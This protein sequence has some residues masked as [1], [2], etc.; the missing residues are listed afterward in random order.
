M[1]YDVYSNGVWAKGR[2]QPFRNQCPSTLVSV[3]EGHA[4]SKAQITETIAQAR[5]AQYHWSRRPQ[6]QRMDILT[7]YA[8][9]LRERNEDI[10]KAISQDMGKP[11]W[12]SR[13]EANAMAAKIDISMKALYERAGD[14]Q[15]EVAFGRTHLIHRAHGVMAV[16]GPFN[17]PG[18]LPNGHIVPALLAGNV[19]VFK[20]SE[21]APSVA[22]LMVEAFEQAGL[23][24]GCFS[25]LQ[26]GREVGQA[27]L[28]SEIDGL[29]FTGSVE[30]GLYFHRYFSGRPE[31]MLALE[32][33]GNNPLI[34]W[35]PVDV[36][37]A[38]N[39]V[40]QSAFITTGQRCSC[41][42]RLILPNTEFANH[43]LE[44][45][46][47]LIDCVKI[48]PWN[49]DDIFMGPLANVRA[50]EQAVSF[51][52]KLVNKG[53]VVLR[54][55]KSLEE[56]SAFVTPGLLDVTHMEN[57]EDEELF[58]PLLQVIKVDNLQ[59]AFDEANQTRF[60][61]AGG[62]I[63]NDSNIWNEAHQTMKAGVL[64]W[65]RPTTG[66]SSALPFGGPGHSGNFRPGA[67]YAADYCA[68]P[69]GSQIADKAQS[70]PMPG[71]P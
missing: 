49:Q 20:P 35:E 52:N 22:K 50:A 61:L 46:S 44:E 58:G 68:W 3:W 45:V 23:P 10:A 36:K 2:G 6:S 19:C 55:L 60:G 31:V 48:G 51:Q 66:A 64:N 39:Q 9:A 12:E 56:H 11:I 62:L 40:F 26:G 59:A 16:L 28:E 43:V 70:L 69:Q 27:L 71:L 21:Q 4:A 41:A 47:R 53:A 34:V 33:G 65:N 38:A 54:A 17:F 30:A 18:H 7:A 5:S 15:S 32:M 13:I 42:R 24:D 8:D 67:Y 29:L 25:V 57:R 63:C 37:S 14:R 1:S